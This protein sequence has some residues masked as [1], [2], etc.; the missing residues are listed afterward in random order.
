[1]NEKEKEKL[2]AA[3]AAIT[4]EDIEWLSDTDAARFRKEREKFNR[5]SLLSR[6]VQRGK[7]PEVKHDARES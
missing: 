5:P 7:K 2:R 3:Y 4:E 6:L 1:M